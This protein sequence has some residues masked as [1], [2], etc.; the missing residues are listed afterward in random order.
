MLKAANKQLK[1]ILE[2]HF[3]ADFVSGH[4]ELHKKTGA[5]IYF[6]PSAGA[7]CKFEHHELHDGEVSG[8]LLLNYT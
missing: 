3:H 2:T 8:L 4:L 1:G 6:G 5:A 7:R